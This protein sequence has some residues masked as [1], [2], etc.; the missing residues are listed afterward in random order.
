MGF[1]VADRGA[2]ED[3]FSGRMLMAQAAKLRK[4]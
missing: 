2:I 4:S 3:G 1:K